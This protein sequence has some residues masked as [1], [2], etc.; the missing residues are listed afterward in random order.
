MTY[1]LTEAA[2]RDLADLYLWG[3]ERFGE[4]KADSYS[5]ALKTTFELLSRHP[6]MARELRHFR[7]PVRV[8]P[9]GSHVIIYRV[10]NDGEILIVRIRHVRENWLSQPLD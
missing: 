10:E 3:A 8:H 1:S 6:F 5:A 9:C 7:T 4:A 2:D